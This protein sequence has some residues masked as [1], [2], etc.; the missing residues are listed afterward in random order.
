MQAQAIRHRGEM[1]GIEGIE[2]LDQTVKLI[3]LY[4][5]RVQQINDKMQVEITKIKDEALAER[6]E[7]ETDRAALLALAETYVKA[8]RD[9]L[10]NG[11]KTRSLN[12][13]KVGFRKSAAKLDIPKKGSDEMVDLVAKIEELAA[14]EPEVFGKIP[15]VIEKTVQKT[16]LTGLSD[17]DLSLLDLERTPGA[18]VFFVEPDRE[19][20]AEGLAKA[21]AEVQDAR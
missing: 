7:I 16:G 1:G 15:V 17:T 9:V 2:D 4:D 11:K 21:I 6:Q 12:F 20:L 13:G 5:I 19:R 3:G 18:D 10:L 8:N 14:V